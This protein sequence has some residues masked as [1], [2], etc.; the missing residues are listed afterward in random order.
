MRIIA[1]P[2]HLA[3][4]KVQYHYQYSTINNIFTN[5]NKGYYSCMA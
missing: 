5:F 4:G 1:K 3:Y 2:D